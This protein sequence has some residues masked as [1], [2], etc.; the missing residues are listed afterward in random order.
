[1][2]YLFLNFFQQ[3]IWLYFFDKTLYVW[4]HIYNLW[5]IICMP[6]SRA[7]PGL[8]SEGR[9]GLLSILMFPVALRNS[10]VCSTMAN[11]SANILRA[12]LAA[13]NHALSQWTHRDPLMQWC[14]H[15]VFLWPHCT[16][17]R[18]LVPWSGIESRSMAVKACWFLIIGPPGK[19]LKQELSLLPFSYEESKRYP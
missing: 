11:N 17:C 3:I 7:P 19:S 12:L 10:Q 18:V 14:K 2:I 5:L 1:M 4:A 13:R 15:F 8:R 9:G 16:A 6:F